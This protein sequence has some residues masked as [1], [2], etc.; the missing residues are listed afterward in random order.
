MRGHI[1]FSFV[2]AAFLLVG[3]SSS[4]VDGYKDLKFGTAKA[5]ILKK[6]EYNFIKAPIDQTGVEMYSCQNFKFG[7]KIVEAAAFFID[8]SFLRFVIVL[9]I[10]QIQGIL[11]SLNE[12]YGAV[13]SSSPQ[14]AF[15]AVDTYPNTEAFLAFDNDTIYVKI[16]SDA[17]RK[18]TAMLL[19]TSPDYDKGLLKIQQT[20]FE[21]DL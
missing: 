6:S 19:Y 7:N 11:A 10:D 16:S 14:E 13:S 17:N 9:P 8:D 12:K 15:A 5:E 2:I 18:Q 20:G 21:G 3:T 1:V 4:A